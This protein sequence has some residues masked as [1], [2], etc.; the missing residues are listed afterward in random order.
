MATIHGTTHHDNDT[1]QWVKCDCS[2]IDPPPRD[3]SPPADL[4]RPIDPFLQKQFFPSLKGASDDDSIFGYQG[5]DKLYG[6]G[7]NDT[8]DGGE[9]IDL[10]Y[11]GSGQDSLSGGNGNDVFDYNALSDSPGFEESNPDG[12]YDS[13][14]D[15]NGNGTAL[16]DRIDLSTIDANLELPGDQAFTQSQLSYSNGIFSANVIGFGIPGS[17]DLQIHLV[18]NPPL[19]VVG[20][21]NDVIL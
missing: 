3:A 7:G 19:D 14:V 8:L 17:L 20:A 2:T 18:G 6:Y 12:I 9:G 11:G 21:T 10:L 5:D 4:W 1:W 16:G 13:I 15:F